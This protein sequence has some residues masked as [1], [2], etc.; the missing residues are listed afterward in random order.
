MYEYWVKV[1]RVVDGDTVDCVIDLGFDIHLRQRVRLLGIDTPE[2]RTRDLEEKQRGIEA[3]KFVEE[4][5]TAAGEDVMIKTEYDS[6]GKFGR[7]LGEFWYK[8]DE[9]WHSLNEV[10]LEKGMAK[11]YGS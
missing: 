5:L 1:E 4:T 7:V 6:R 10:L 3:K 11:P 8:D 9:G 2:V